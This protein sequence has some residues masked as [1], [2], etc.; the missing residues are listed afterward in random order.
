MSQR[1]NRRKIDLIP[2]PEWADPPKAQI[3]ELLAAVEARSP[4]PASPASPEVAEL[5]TAGG[6]RRG[7]RRSAGDE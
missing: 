6:S 7:P 5:A 2:L 1:L 4:P 3:D